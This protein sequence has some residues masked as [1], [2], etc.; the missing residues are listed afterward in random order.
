MENVM[1]ERNKGKGQPEYSLLLLIR[2]ASTHTQAVWMR[3]CDPVSVGPGTS[4]VFEGLLP[5]EKSVHRSMGR[6]ATLV[7]GPSL[8][9]LGILTGEV[10][11]KICCFDK[12]CWME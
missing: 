8:R 11:K 10:L 12:S 9:V 3:Q 1:R 2:T 5:Q 7:N 6:G 4:G